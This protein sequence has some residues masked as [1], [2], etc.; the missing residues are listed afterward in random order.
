M[1]ACNFLCGTSY[2]PGRHYATLLE[3]YLGR[4]DIANNVEEGDINL[5]SEARTLTE[6]IQ[7]ALVSITNQQDYI[8]LATFQEWLQENI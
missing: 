2:V 3:K 7:E 4:L 6:E 5:N 8:D 1:S